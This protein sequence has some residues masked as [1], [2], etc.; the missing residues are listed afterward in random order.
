MIDWLTQKLIDW[1]IKWLIDWLISWLIDWLIDWFID[2]HYCFQ[3][4]WTP[5]FAMI[6]GYR[7]NFSLLSLVIVVSDIMQQNSSQ[8]CSIRQITVANETMKSVTLDTHAT[9]KI[10]RILSWN[11]CSYSI[12]VKLEFWNVGFSW[13][14][15]TGVPGEKPSEQGENQQQTQP[16]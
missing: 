9:R 3:N 13:G 12:L 11:S 14:R 5:H 4:P 2:S 16:T 7:Q 6:K 10:N 15:K 1:L 8:I